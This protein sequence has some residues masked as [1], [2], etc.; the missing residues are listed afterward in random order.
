MPQSA[1]K[2]TRV[3]ELI[4]RG[5]K[6]DAEGGTGTRLDVARVIPGLTIFLQFF[7]VSLWPRTDRGIF[8]RRQKLTRLRLFFFPFVFSFPFSFFPFFLRL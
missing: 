8:R 7:D 4:G 3:M 6:R 1:G 2:G 5:R